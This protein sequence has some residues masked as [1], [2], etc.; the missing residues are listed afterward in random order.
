MRVTDA[1]NPVP[2]LMAGLWT[3]L[4][5][6]AAMTTATVYVL[7]RMTRDKPVPI[8]PQESDVEDYSVV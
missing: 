3:V 6:Y 2:G 4:V 1:V 5:V 7:R 8:A